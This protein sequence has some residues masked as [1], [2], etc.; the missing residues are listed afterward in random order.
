MH[1]HSPVCSEDEKANQWP[2][3]AEATVLILLLVAFFLLICWTKG[4]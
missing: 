3:W 4:A 2:F 1:V